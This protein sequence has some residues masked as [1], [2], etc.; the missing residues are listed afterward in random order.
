MGM[1][2]FNATVGGDHLRISGQTLPLWKLMG[3]LYQ[4][5]EIAWSYLHSSEHNTG[6]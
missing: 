5:L 6:V 3:L 4:M 1:T 2:H